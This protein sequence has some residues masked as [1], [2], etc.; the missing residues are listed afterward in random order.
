M[1]L[2]DAHTHRTYNDSNMT[3][4]RSIDI[5]SAERPE[6]EELH[7][8][9]LHPWKISK[10][11]QCSDYVDRLLQYY[12]KHRHC[13]AIGEVGL[14]RSRGDLELQKAFFNQLYSAARRTKAPP[15]L[16]L[17]CVKSVSDFLEVFSKAPYP[18]NIIFH[19]FNGN[20]TE[21]NQLLK[22]TNVFFSFGSS[23]L[24]T[25]SKTMAFLPHLPSDRILVESDDTDLNILKLHEV[26][27]T[28]HKKH[29][30]SFE[31][32]GLLIQT[33]FHRAFPRTS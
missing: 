29:Y 23:L 5:L 14:D 9:G 28:H 27:L 1:Q 4:I 10:N 11:Q 21:A 22:K 8:L 3:S 16:V 25:N 12:C 20:L 18:S 17:H 26:I 33:N 7:S 19:D 6:N 13:A 30:G 32:F 24:R 15:P 2:Y 31:D